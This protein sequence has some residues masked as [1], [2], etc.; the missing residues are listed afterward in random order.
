[1]ASYLSQKVSI[2]KDSAGNE[3]MIDST[4][5]H[6]DTGT[7][8]VIVNLLNFSGDSSTPTD[9]SFTIN[10]TERGRQI[11]V[12]G[13]MQ[14]EY[15]SVIGY[16]DCDII[17]GASESDPAVLRVCQNTTSGESYADLLE[18]HSSDAAAQMPT[19]FSIL[20]AH[21]T[22]GLLFDAYDP[23]DTPNNTASITGRF[24]LYMRPKIQR[25]DPVEF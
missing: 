6:A 5:V 8:T 10:T 25:D 21:G 14:I 1:M 13:N 4:E 11:K 15:D 16:W 7:S 9:G 22:L 12:L 3:Y 20:R 17:K 19:D 18:I 24:T 2:L 23:S